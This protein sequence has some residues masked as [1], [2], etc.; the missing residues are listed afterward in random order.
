MG[1]IHLL[2]HWD[3]KC[4]DIYLILSLHVCTNPEGDGFGIY[5]MKK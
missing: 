1:D 4:Q 2:V 3:G 5:Q